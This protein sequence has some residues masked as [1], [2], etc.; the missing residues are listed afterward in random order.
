M[1][2]SLFLWITYLAVVGI[3]FKLCCPHANLAIQIIFRSLSLAAWH[4]CVSLYTSH[5]VFD[6][7][8][9]PLPA[10]NLHLYCRFILG[11]FFRLQSIMIYI[12]I[13]QQRVRNSIMLVQHILIER[14][15]NN[16]LTVIFTFDLLIL[17]IF[18]NW[19]ISAKNICQAMLVNFAEWACFRWCK[20]RIR[21]VTANSILPKHKRFFAPRRIPESIENTLLRKQLRGSASLK[22]LF[23]IKFIFEHNPAQKGKINKLE[24]HSMWKYQKQLFS[25]SKFIICFHQVTGP[26]NE[27]NHWQCQT[28]CTQIWSERNDKRT[29][30]E[31]KIE[32]KLVTKFTV[33]LIWCISFS[34]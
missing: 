19:F 32:R 15:S 6:S 10:C 34:F 2:I 8:K 23:N 12:G 33:H 22:Y 30:R 25:F 3:S 28:F 21:S 20:V 16:Q 26:N 11:K 27:N 1:K 14:G 4:D 29:R 7:Q 13:L 5:A 24:S 31:W 17:V 9:N 18:A